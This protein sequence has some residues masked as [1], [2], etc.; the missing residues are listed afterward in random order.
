MK[1][2]W[3]Y[4]KIKWTSFFV[5][6]AILSI[7]F[8]IMYVP[9]L[10]SPNEQ[11]ITK[12]K[13]HPVTPGFYSNE[14]FS[15]LIEE[16][17][18]EFNF[19]ESISF[20]SKKEGHYTIQGIL[21]NPK[22]LLVLCEELKPYSLLL[23]AL[24]GESIQISGHLGENEY[25]NGQ[26]V[27]DTITFSEYTLPAT[28]ATEYIDKYTGLNDLLEA[29]IETI[30]IAEDGITFTDKIPLFIQTASCISNPSSFSE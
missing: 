13:Q 7:S 25:G 28:I 18:S 24:Q 6:V 30:S 27:F 26:F 4:R 29:S 8:A 12:A 1:N 20:S 2:N 17:L 14:E 10:L 19:I 16:N 21:T 15:K 11:P 3:N 9:P 22:R 5:T 23:D